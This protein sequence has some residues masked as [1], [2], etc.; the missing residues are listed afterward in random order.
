M[1]EIDGLAQPMGKLDG[2]VQPMGCSRWDPE[3]N[4]ISSD[5][6]WGTAVTNVLS[7]W[8]Q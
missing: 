4:L 6:V 1:G 3:K 8:V 5:P 7:G 2:R